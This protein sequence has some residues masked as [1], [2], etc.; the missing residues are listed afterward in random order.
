MSAPTTNWQTAMTWHPVR[1]SNIHSV[2]H[3]GETLAVRFVDNKCAG[4]G[5]SNQKTPIAI[6][7]GTDERETC[8][9]CGG[10]GYVNTYRYHPAEDEGPIPEAT[11]AAIRDS[12]SPGR[13]FREFVKGH[14]GKVEK[15]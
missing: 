9:T 11:M 1:S 14:K 2:G 7:R 5:K 15:F 6:A 4:T 12:D 13:A 8:A 3:D 10:T